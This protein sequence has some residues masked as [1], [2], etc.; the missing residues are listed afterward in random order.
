MP[1][2]IETRNRPDYGHGSSEVVDEPGLRAKLLSGAKWS[3][4]LRLVTQIYSWA[5]TLLM[6]RLLTPQ[7]YG[8]N[9]MVEAPIE[10][11]ALLGTLGV[12]AAL[13][14]SGIRDPRRLASAFGFLLAVNS[15]LFVVLFVGA[16]WIAD[17]FNA[18]QLE[19][20]IR[21][22]AVIFV[23]APFR[24]I[25]NALLDMDLD[26]KLKAQVE[27]KA[28]VIAS[29]VG[30]G[31]ALAGA[32]VWALVA[33]IV[34]SAILKAAL[35][36]WCRPWFLRPAL[37][38]TLSRPLIL[39]G[40]TIIA[41][42]MLTMLA[43]KSVSALGGPL[44]GAEALGLYAVASLFSYLPINKT[45]PII[46]QVLF[47]AYARLAKDP[48]LTRKYILN[49]MELS[50]IT[51]VPA[52]IGMAVVAEALVATFFGERWINVAAPL[53]ILSALTPVRLLHLMFQSPLNAN[54]RAK[55]VSGLAAL[56]LVLFSIGVIPAASYGVPGLLVLSALAISILATVTTTMSCRVFNLPVKDL[57]RAIIRPLIA[58]AVMALAVYA[59]RGQLAGWPPGVVLAVEVAIGAVGYSLTLYLLM[60]ERLN[61]LR[62]V[63]LTRNAPV[64]EEMT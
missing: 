59:I 44:L 37:D 17:Y 46:Q 8:L 9:A 39:Y 16:P 11:L 6:V 21:V 23:L 45:M 56:N 57:L 60:G 40:L 4:M 52:G 38:W 30:F 31:L 19:T 7:D 36:A 14:R 35:L 32:G 13:I 48:A 12:D 5:I 1:D 64:Q 51:I 47:P 27:L 34:V 2:P 58:C 20:L 15:L 22:A 61:Q 55:L 29:L 25:P 62:R 26:F 24:I 33:V 10:V 54:G 49:A 63:L 41:G 53:A 50:F 28:T 3:V 18:P 42:T 43:G